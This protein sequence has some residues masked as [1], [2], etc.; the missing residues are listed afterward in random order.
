MN[1]LVFENGFMIESL[2]AT[3]KKIDKIVDFD[4]VVTPARELI[5]F[6]QSPVYPPLHGPTVDITVFCDFSRT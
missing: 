6:E 3:F 4:T 1:A 2:K 5:G